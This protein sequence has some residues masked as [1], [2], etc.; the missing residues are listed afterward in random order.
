MSLEDI[1]LDT[2]DSESTEKRP[3]NILNAYKE[4]LKVLKHAQEYAHKGEI[5]K[6]VEKYNLYLGTLA[7]Y[8]KV[9]EADLK[10]N[11]FDAKKEITE[12]LLISHAYWDLA[13]S[14]DRSPRLQKESVRCLNQFVVFSLGFKYQHVNAQM[15]KKLLRK[16]QVHNRK[17]FQQAYDRLNVESKACYV[18][19]YA[20]PKNEELLNTLRT[21]KKEIYTTKVGKTFVQLYYEVSPR[22]IELL[23]KFPISAKLL[24]KLILRPLIKS[25][26]ILIKNVSN[27]KTDK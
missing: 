1:D 9:K 12:M 23:N 2:G 7:A 11:L 10:P 25:C 26:Y 22:F 18:A 21:F 5:P 24:T 19:T 16:K 13:K 14:Y 4:R 3:E 15:L 6:A 20:Y 17:A 8:F 27:K